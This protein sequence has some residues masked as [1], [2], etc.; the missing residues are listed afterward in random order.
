[1]HRGA[2][3]ISFSVIDF[4]IQH[5]QFTTDLSLMVFTQMEIG[6]GGGFVQL[7]HPWRN[8]VLHKAGKPVGMFQ[9]SMGPNPDALLFRVYFTGSFPA[10]TTG[11]VAGML[12]TSRFRAEKGH[13][14]DGAVPTA[15]AG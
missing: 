2:N 11:A 4:F 9:P 5:M 12:G 8:L 10:P 7:P 13:M 15:L 14:L 6:P 1:M 3:N